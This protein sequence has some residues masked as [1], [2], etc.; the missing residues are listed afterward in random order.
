MPM[1]L[2]TRTAIASTR[3]EDKGYLLTYE[4]ARLPP[5]RKR[6]LKIV[7]ASLRQRPPAKTRAATILIRTLSLITDQ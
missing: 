4:V 1:L 5:I 3:P 7:T 6:I 2:K